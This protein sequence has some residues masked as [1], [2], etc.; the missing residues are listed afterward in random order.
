MSSSQ[1]IPTDDALEWFL[2]GFTAA[3]LAEPLLSVDDDAAISAALTVL[4]TDVNAVIGVR[5]QGVMHG[6]LSLAEL[7]NISDLHD[8]RPFD[9]ATV[10]SDAASLNDVVCMLNDHAR[11][12][13]RA[14]G[15]ICGVINRNAVESPPMRMWLFG[16]VTISE[17]R[18]TRLIA[19]SLPDDCWTAY[20]S[21]GR[22]QKAQELQHL[23]NSRGQRP[24]LLDC[25]QFADKGQIVARDESL[26]QRTRF[27]SRKE[28]ERF[29]QALQDLR[30]NLAHSQDITADWNVIYD[31]A[32]NLHDIVCGPV[33]KTEEAARP[34]YSAGSR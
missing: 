4:G 26:R 2:R 13:V 17:Q 18:V 6:W 34:S 10:I 5:H 7:A 29:V 15:Q 9:A 24:S 11:L 30:N 21:A 25:L 16:L 32:A 23:R 8:C 27:P 14:F 1:T 28:V 20:L 31:L 33:G 3:D 22:L 12:F 19:E